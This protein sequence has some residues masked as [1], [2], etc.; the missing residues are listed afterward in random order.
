MTQLFSARENI[1]G[2]YEVLFPIHQTTYGESYRVKNLEDGKLYMLKLYAKDKLKEFHFNEEGI[3][4]EAYLHSNLDHNNIVR[5]VEHKNLS[6]SGADY[7]YYVVN[8]ISGE[9]LKERIDREGPPSYLTCM[10]IMEKI[11]EALSYLH[12]QKNPIVHADVSP[13]NIMLDYSNSS[14]PVLFDFGLSRISGAEKVHYNQT[15][16]SAFFAAPEQ[17][18]GGL[19]EQSDVFSFGALLYYMLT[20][21]YPWSTNLNN[22][23]PK[24]ADFSNDLLAARNRTLT[25]G[26][27]LNIDEQVKRC[28]VKSMLP[29]HS[30]RF[31]SVEEFMQYI[32]GNQ[33]VDLAEV[34]REEQK[35][36]IT[37]KKGEGFKKLAGMAQLKEDIQFEVI[38]PLL[39]PEAGKKYGIQAPNAVLFFGPPGCGKTYFAECLAEEVGFNFIKVAPSDVGSTFV[40]GAQE[41][42]KKLFEGAKEN[43]PTILFLDEVDAMIPERSANMGHHYES[44]VNEWLI[45]INNCAKDNIFIIGATNRLAKIDKAVLRAGRF[46]RKIYIPLPDH[47]L[48]M[49]LFKLDFDKIPDVIEGTINYEK[50]AELTEGFVSSDISLICMDVRR[51]TY[52]RDINITQAIVEDVISQSSTSISEESMKEYQGEKKSEQRNLIGFN[53]N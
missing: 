5:Y 52:R 18:Q 10:N 16:P 53:R 41:K 46:D 7:V 51:L 23:D 35:Q 17:I 13:L 47:E 19:S 9:T 21:D 28:I 39:N 43:A 22:H 32:K 45:Q 24:H 12:K 50:L 31:S 15:L 29:E 6:I 8:F 26:P 30:T 44:E 37:K 3:L 40:H 25:Y 14:N 27:S 1:D 34:K 48:R 2:K 49:A 4:R 11:G 38:Q 20:G 36:V 42:I 33:Q